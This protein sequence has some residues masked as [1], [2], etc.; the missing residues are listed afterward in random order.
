[1]SDLERKIREARAH[2][3]GTDLRF[4]R[5]VNCISLAGVDLADLDER[6][7]VAWPVAIEHLPRPVLMPA[8]VQALEPVVALT[9]GVPQKGP[10]VQSAWDKWNDVLTAMVMAWDSASVKW[11]SLADYALDVRESRAGVFPQASGEWARLI[12]MTCE[13]GPYPGIDAIVLPVHTSPRD[14]ETRPSLN[15][16]MKAFWHPRLIFGLVEEP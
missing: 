6:V 10:P 13:Q 1:M 9:R 3:I 11:T 5:G 15:A 14:P 4:C 12:D 2:K 8:I 16:A 7:R